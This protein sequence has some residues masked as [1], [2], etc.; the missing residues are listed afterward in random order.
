MSDERLESRQFLMAAGV[1]VFIVFVTRALAFPHSWWLPVEP[2]LGLAMQNFDPLAGQP[3]APGFP[4]YLELAGMLMFKAKSPFVALVV[5]AY[6]SSI[7]ATVLL[8]AAFRRISRDA[9]GGALASLLL[10][11]TPAMLVFSSTP[12]PE[13]SALMFFAV[14]LNAAAKLLTDEATSWRTAA[15]LGAGVAGTVGCQPEWILPALLV[16]LAPLLAPAARRLLPIAILTFVAGAALVFASL[17]NALGGLGTLLRW[18]GVVTTGA[19]DVSVRAILD[20]FG[21]AWLAIPIAVLALAGL[22]AAIRARETLLLL[23]VAPA[24]LNVLVVSWRGSVREPVLALLLAIVAISLFAIRGLT[25]LGSRT[26]QPWIRIAAMAVF[27]LLSWV[28]VSP[29]L[30]ARLKT[31][32]PPSKAAIWIDDKIEAGAVVLVAD[33]LMPYASALIA[34]AKLVPLEG[35]GSDRSLAWY[36]LIPGESTEAGAVVFSWPESEP[37]R[38]LAGSRH[39]IV[40]VVPIHPPAPAP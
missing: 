25:E 1:A 34:K 35:A 40:S 10:F 30:L 27:C 22:V 12:A 29:L 17:A 20:A 28:W 13:A 32:P 16:L 33:D 31:A 3:P 24:V 2:L 26:G 5:A 38:R 37:L 6:L 18:T 11:M 14:A 4:L 15:L 21:P 36:A 7:A 9:V 39:R 23:V 19:A 8:A